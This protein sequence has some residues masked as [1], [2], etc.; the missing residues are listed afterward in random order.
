MFDTNRQIRVL[1]NWLALVGLFVT[2]LVVML[3][4]LAGS[5]V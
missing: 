4:L 3:L 2:G 5:G 1:M